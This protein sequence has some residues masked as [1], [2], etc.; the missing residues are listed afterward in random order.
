[1]LEKNAYAYMLNSRG[2]VKDPT[3]EAKDLS[4]D[5]KDFKMCREFHL[6]WIVYVESTN[7]QLTYIVVIFLHSFFA[8]VFEF[9]LGHFSF[10]G[11]ARWR[12]VFLRHHI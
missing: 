12:R 1:M 2:G 7:N 3:F 5:A 8:V 6:C 9:F 10:D 11:R 4:F